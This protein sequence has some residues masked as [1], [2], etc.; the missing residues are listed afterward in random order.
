[1]LKHICPWLL[2]LY[3]N[4]DEGGAG[5][6]AGSGTSA[7][8]GINTG[9]SGGGTGDSG[10]GTSGGGNGGQGSG[11]GGDEGTKPK[12]TQ[13]ELDA[14]AGRIRAE[15][16]R[17]FDDA[18][19]AEKDRVE[20]EK[21]KEQGQFKELYEKLQA[22][23]A[24]EY[25]PAVALAAKLSEQLNEVIDAQIKDW[26]ASVR[27]LDPGKDDVQAR[28]EWVKKSG[29]LAE[30]VMAGKRAP[31]TENGDKGGGAGDAKAATSYVNKKYQRPKLPGIAQ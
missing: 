28:S 19:Q 2:G 6:G 13:A 9:G 20:S 31:N 14:H 4:K 8:E 11:A 3:L 18:L 10:Q 17:K 25:K 12:F 16:K 21:A 30:E 15:E 5:G 29:K 27:N 1:M 7:G 23:E 26:P 22:K 24:A